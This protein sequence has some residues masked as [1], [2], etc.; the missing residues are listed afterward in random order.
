MV[1]I[2]EIFK[3]NN[4]LEYG[5]SYLEKLYEIAE[6][7]ENLRFA[8]LNLMQA[9]FDKKDDL[10]SIEFSSKVLEIEN[11]DDKL[12]W[13][14]NLIKARSLMRI[15]DTLNSLKVY[16][17]LEK[18]SD[19]EKASEALYYKAYKNFKDKKFK[20]SIEVITNISK[21]SNNFNYWTV[22]AL[23][24]LSKNYISLNDNFQAVF[25]L[26]SL[27]ENFNNYPNLVSESKSLLDA[28]SEN[29]L[30]KDI[31]SNNENNE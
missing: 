3:K 25:I 13:D 31:N 27:I 22:K 12:K 16:E 5:I 7:Q 19:F 1:R 23:L 17:K 4:D 14:A 10:K 24:L 20:S 2:I 28:I 11:I 8:L 15:N 26:E 9:Y 29:K 21:L 30:E 18:I 6:F